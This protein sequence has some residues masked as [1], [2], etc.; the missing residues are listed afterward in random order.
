MRADPPVMQM[1]EKDIQR[2]EGPDT[3]NSVAEY[4]PLKRQVTSFEE[5]CSNVYDGVILTG[6]S[7]SLSVIYRYLSEKE[8]LAGNFNR[9]TNFYREFF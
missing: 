7:N 3:C 9:D 6:V 8:R 2:L 1:M 5:K 4:F